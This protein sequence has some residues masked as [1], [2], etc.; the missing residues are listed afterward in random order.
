MFLARAHR[1]TDAGEEHWRGGNYEVAYDAYERAREEYG[2]ALALDRT[3]SET[4]ERIQRERD[5]LDRIVA[6][7]EQSP[8][9]KAVTADNE[10][11]A[12]DGPETAADRW[13][14]A[15]SHY[16]TVLE[17]DWGADRRRFAGDPQLI[18]DRL[19]TVAESLTTARRTV[20]NDAMRAG[21]WYADADQYELAREQFETALDAFEAA[22]ATARDCYPDAVSHLRAERDA[23]KQRLDRTEATLDG[24]EDVTDRI[25]T[26]DEPEYAVSGTLGE[27]DAE[28]PT[29]LDDIDEATVADGNGLDGYPESTTERLRKL[30]RPALVDIVT[31]ALAETVCSTQVAG[32]ET[33][34]DLLARREDELIGVIVHTPAGTTAEPDAVRRC[35]AASDAA[36][37]DA[38]MLAT[39][40]RP[41]DELS[42]LAAESDVQV[43]AADSISAIVDAQGLS[44]PGPNRRHL[45]R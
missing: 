4:A 18:R 35:A 22:L 21:D 8:L 30:D 32:A 15:L 37:T 39:T 31:D 16:R 36:D 14:E 33:P 20:A 42:K 44:L 26:D 34:F 25:Q 13:A 40:G 9:R 5:R 27:V 24:D 23:V 29:A 1:A 45:K 17:V 38:V 41:T 19:S 12:A 2:A 7:L 43:F 3:D 6:K 11:V 10:A 28:G